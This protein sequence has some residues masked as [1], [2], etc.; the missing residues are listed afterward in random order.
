MLSI[1][2]FELKKKNVYKNEVIDKSNT[3]IHHQ[4]HKNPLQSDTL[5]GNNSEYITS[6]SSVTTISRNN[7]KIY[8]FFSGIIITL[9]MVIF[10]LS[11][12]GKSSKLIQQSKE[13]MHPY[14]EVM[15]IDITNG[16]PDVSQEFIDNMSS[17]ELMGYSG[18]V[19]HG[20]NEY[21]SKTYIEL[22]TWISNKEVSKEEFYDF[23]EQM[24][25]YFNYEAKL[26]SF[27]YIADE[28]W[29]W[30]DYDEKCDVIAWYEDNKINISWDWTLPVIGEETPIQTQE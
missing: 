7:T 14:F 13:N 19:T 17:V 9:I 28:T 21:D 18:S 22:L 30:M 16:L 20:Y 4:D 12:P 25:L 8:L 15:G 3:R 6:K 5:I 26:A 11:N 10:I 1:K 2:N 27:P 29:Q 24:N 23:V